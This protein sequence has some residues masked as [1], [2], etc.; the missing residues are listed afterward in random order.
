MLVAGNGS[1]EPL[2]YTTHNIC[3]GLIYFQDDSRTIAKAIVS[4]KGRENVHAKDVRDLI[5][6]MNNQQ[7]KMGVLVTMR[8]TKAMVEAAREA[9]SVEAGGQMHRRVQIATIKDLLD[10]SKPDLPPGA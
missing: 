5:G 6:A 7:A 10:G 3:F 4:V 1:T 8:K 9:G 2:F